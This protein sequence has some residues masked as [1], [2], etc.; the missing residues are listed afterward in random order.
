MMR[1]A[2]Q[3]Y[4]IPLEGSGFPPP[5]LHHPGTQQEQDR[6]YHV[7]NKT[8]TP[9]ASGWKPWDEH[10]NWDPELHGE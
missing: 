9:K 2:V 6:A 7:L 10:K 3:G 1:A 8:K 4:R 5:P